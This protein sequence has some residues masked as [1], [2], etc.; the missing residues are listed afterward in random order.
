MMKSDVVDKVAEKAGMKK[1]E[2]ERA[3]NA[4]LDTV[5][6][7]L[8]NGEKVRFLGFGTFQVVE[9][10]AR[11]GHDPRSGNEIKI[12]ARN[13]PQFKPGKPLKDSIN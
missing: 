9:R 10:K 4:F 1:I 3:V 8:M 7:G 11:L 2:A 6:Q 5:K 13:I 12:A